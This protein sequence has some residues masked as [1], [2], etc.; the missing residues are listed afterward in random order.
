MSTVEDIIAGARPGH[1][2]PS[3]C[4]INF[5]DDFDMMAVSTGLRAAW[6]GFPLLTEGGDEDTDDAS[7][8]TGRII[9]S[10][11]RDP[12][13]LKG[14][15][16]PNPDTKDVSSRWRSGLYFM[17]NHV[18][19]DVMRSVSICSPAGAIVQAETDSPPAPK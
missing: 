16:R 17:W 19:V 6:T 10:V 2:D 13:N 14:E 9:N 12:D 1:D 15:R 3:F 8:R 5:A 7:A 18:F 11:Y 4:R